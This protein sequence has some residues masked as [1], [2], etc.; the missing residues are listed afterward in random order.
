MKLTIQNIEFEVVKG[1]ITAQPGLEAVVNAAN[2]ELSPGGGVAGA[3]HKAAG[4]DLYKECKPL[5]PIQPGEAV[6]TNAYQLPN[7]YVI[8][9]LGPVYGQD[10]PESE[11]LA[12][13][14]RNT[15]KI[16]E[17]MEITSLGFPAISTGIFGYPAELAVDVVF[18][19]VLA[20]LSGIEKIKKIKFVLF[21]D[22]DLHLYETQLKKISVG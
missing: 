5:A 14:Y 19:T 8:H 4:P 12:A 21:S 15:L 9:C 3:I 7:K 18:N 20:E 6:L 10:K 22:K 1:D 13:C 2:A 11:L 16:A 17:E